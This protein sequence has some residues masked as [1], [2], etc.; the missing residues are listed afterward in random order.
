MLSSKLTR[1]E[2]DSEIVLSWLRNKQSVHTQKQYS[3][4]IEHFLQFTGKNLSQIMIEDIQ[5]YL[6]SLKLR[7]QKVSTIKVKLM[8]IKSLFSYCVKTGYLPLNPAAMVDNPRV[9]D[10]ISQKLLTVED[11]KMLMS[12]TMG[13]RDK[14]LIKIMFGLGLR[15][16]EAINLRWVNFSVDGEKVNLT[17]VGKGNR[18][19]TVLVI[20]SLWQELQQLRKKGT[21]YLFTASKDNVP[22]R[23]NTAHNMLKKVGRKAGLN[24]DLSCHWLRHSH[25]TEAIK[26]GCDLSLLQQS[27]GH[28]SIITTQKYLCLRKNEGSGNYINL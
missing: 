14:L 21:D 5:D 18:Q 15:V 11:V 1:A 22:M 16:S 28:S 25:A 8:T 13:I 9:N 27:L 6:R 17:I 24:Q 4:T 10:N 7:N 26:G 2:N 12:H 20:P 3:Y 23:R 19:R